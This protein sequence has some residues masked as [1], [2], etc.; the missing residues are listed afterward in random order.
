MV[1]SADQAGPEPEETL[2]ALDKGLEE[3]LVSGASLDVNWGTSA[4]EKDTITNI[5]QW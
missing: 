4:A 3:F 1:S 2:P 5:K